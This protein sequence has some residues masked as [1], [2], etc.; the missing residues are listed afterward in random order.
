MRIYEYNY[1]KVFFLDKIFIFL[2]FLFIR[3]EFFTSRVDFDFGFS[4]YFEFFVDIF[5][6]GFGDL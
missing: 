5:C 6:C 3:F 1:V 4:S 2:L